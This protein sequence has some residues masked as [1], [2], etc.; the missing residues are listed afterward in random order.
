[1]A[2]GESACLEQFLL[3]SLCFQKPVCCRGVRNIYMR[4]R[5]NNF[6]HT[7]NAQQTSLKTLRQKY[8]N[9]LYIIEQLLNEIENSVA[10]GEIS[11][12]HFFKPKY[13]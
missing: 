2:K 9:S 11:C 3:L 4:E 7:T 5:V 10:K 1:M 8:E 12:P 13:F 6:P